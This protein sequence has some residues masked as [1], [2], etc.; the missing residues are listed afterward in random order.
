VGREGEGQAKL[1]RKL[2]AEQARTQYPHLD[3]AIGIGH[4]LHPLAALWRRKERLKLE[5]ILREML[6]AH[7]IAAERAG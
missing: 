1:C 4:R 6:R 5:H 2:R 7:R 3:L